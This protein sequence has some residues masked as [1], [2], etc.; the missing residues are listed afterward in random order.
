MT[1]DRGK[2]DEVAE[3]LSGLSALCDT[4]FALA[5]HIRFAA[6]SLLYRNYPPDWIATYS[7]KGFMLSDPVV[8]YGLANTGTVIWA[9]LAQND[10]AGV[11][12]AALAHGLT[13]GWTYSTGPAN[14]RTICGFTRSGAAF[15]AGQMDLGR[16][17]V[18]R[19]HALTDGI[20]HFPKDMLDALRALMPG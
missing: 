2:I 16:A 6:P 11:L 14:S 7:Q 15:S 20:E 10:P 9:D 4:G 13:N 5:A 17:S 8:H 3:H 1:F 19:I 12:S 18:D